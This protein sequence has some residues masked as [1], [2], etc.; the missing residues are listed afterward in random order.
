MGVALRKRELPSGNIQLFLDISRGSS[1][2]KR[3]RENLHL[4]LTGDRMQDKETLRMAQLIRATREK[5]LLQDEHGLSDTRKRKGSFVEYYEKLKETKNAENTR[6]SWEQ[7]LKHFKEF[8][9]GDVSIAGLTREKLEGFKTYLLGE[10]SANSA[11][12]YFAHV[13]SALGQAVKDGIF[14]S[15]PAEYITIRKTKHHPIFLSL[16]EVK[17]LSQTPWRDENVK[18]A[19]LFSCFTGLRYSDIASLKWSQIDGEY[20]SFNQRKTAAPERL[21]ISEGAQGILKLQ[22]KVT[23]EK[24]SVFNLPHHS[25]LDDQLKAWGELA[26]LKKKLSIHK[27]RHTFACLALSSGVD[28]YTTSKLLGHKNLHTTQI[29]AQVIDERKKQAVSLLPSL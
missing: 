28:I 9:G 17:K 25:T 10:V 11:D 13:K 4:V 6:I 26:G 2:S 23:G 8:V 15:N 14:G 27:G 12:L 3:V 22:K 5:E 29:Y 16:D 1:R 18:N 7:G 20:V 24:A 21:P 19:F